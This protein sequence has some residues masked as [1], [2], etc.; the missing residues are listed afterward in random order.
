MAKDLKKSKKRV[1][2]DDRPPTLDIRGKNFFPEIKQL[3]IDDEVELVIKA[4][5]TR[6]EEGSYPDMAIGCCGCEDDD[7]GDDHEENRK[8][9]QSATFEITSITSNGKV[10]K[11]SS[12]EGKVMKRYAELTKKGVSSDA[13]MKMAKAGK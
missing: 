5:L 2:W 6:K 11:P 1:D 8:K 12:S 10:K 3:Q 13:A 4:K 9:K 7:C